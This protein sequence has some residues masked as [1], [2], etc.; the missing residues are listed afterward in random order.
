MNLAHYQVNINTQK[1]AGGF[2]TSEEMAR[3]IQL[4][5]LWT[6]FLLI[7]WYIQSSHILNEN[8]SDSCFDNIIES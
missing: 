2:K 5:Q 3:V 1:N 8:I 4:L 6:P 7:T